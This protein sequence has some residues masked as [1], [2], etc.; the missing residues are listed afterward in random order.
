MGATLGGS[1]AKD[2]LGL[3]I[4]L[5][6]RPTNPRVVALCKRL[7]RRQLPETVAIRMV[8]GWSLEA[9]EPGPLGVGRER[10][11]STRPGPHGVP[12]TPE[13]GAHHAFTTQRSSARTIMQTPPVRG[14]CIS[15]SAAQTCSSERER[16]FAAYMP[17]WKMR[18]NHGF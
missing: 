1:L 9:E 18:R 7:R 14:T 10:T 12:K 2:K 13:Q 4:R 3:P 17:M 6:A 11:Q 8:R 15:S 5:L 16:P